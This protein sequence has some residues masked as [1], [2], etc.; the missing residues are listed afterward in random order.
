MKHLHL[1]RQ[2]LQSA[3]ASV[4]HQHAVMKPVENRIAYD[5]GIGLG[6]YADADAH[7][8]ID[9]VTLQQY[10]RPITQSLIPI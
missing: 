8:A 4:A 6:L 9:V 3:A 2:Y 7:V 5:K 1:T 10:P